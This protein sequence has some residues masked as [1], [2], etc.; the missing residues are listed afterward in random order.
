M[1]NILYILKYASIYSY[2]ETIINELIAKNYRVDICIMKENISGSTKYEIAGKDN[3]KTLIA[4]NLENG[5]EQILIRESEKIKI[6]RGVSRKDIWVKPLILVRETLNLLSYIRR[7][8]DGTFFELQKRCTP[9]ITRNLLTSPI[10]SIIFTKLPFF[11]LILKFLESIIPKSRN[12]I[13]F[14]K[15]QNYSTIV[16]VGANWS[17]TYN[18]FSSEID[19]IKAGKK[20]GI[21][22]VMQVVSWDNLTAR[23]LYH[24]VPD[25][26]LVWNKQHSIEAK[27]IHSIPA[28][29][30]FITGSPFMDKW[31]DEKN[32][33]I[34]KSN[35]KLDAPYVT[36]LGSSQNITRDET[37]VVE[38]LHKELKKNNIDLVVRPHGANYEQFR[39]LKD[40][41]NVIPKNGD[42][43][44][45]KESKE[46][47][48]S[49]I[50]NSIAT[51][52]IN[53]TAMVD[54]LI[55]GTKCF[56]IT[57][58]EFYKNQLATYHFK[59]I[60][61]YDL[62]ITTDSEIDCINQIINLTEDEEFLKKRERFI[63]DFCRPLGM[64]SKAGKI[65]ANKIIE[66][67]S[68]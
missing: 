19:Y 11:R 16:V 41:I 17:S 31:F 61:D 46:L 18:N 66:I 5:N 29:N 54:S 34:L 25:L 12:I 6:K 3:E 36:Y 28:N 15:S 42:L 52:G 55:L 47:M 63:I 49:T 33:S 43:P 45:T 44:D 10:I 39:K 14:I 65:S 30:I 51:I 24:E 40:D 35:L 1:Q 62:L 67:D 56:A 59:T 53:T 50:K 37:M 26:F 13:D 64:D 22:T 38:N 68:N 4:K 21:K 8:D 23:G 48:I 20:L 57:K 2:S 60:L 7:R 58:P 32:E 9:K 27:K